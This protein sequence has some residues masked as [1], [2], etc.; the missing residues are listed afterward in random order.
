MSVTKEDVVWCYQNLL[1]REPESAEVVAAHL[2]KRD[3]KQLIMGFLDSKEFLSHKLGVNLAGVSANIGLPPVLDKLDID[4][5]ATGEELGKCAAKIKAAWEHLGNEKPHWS[6]LAAAAYLPDN[7]KVSIDRFWTTGAM[8]AAQAIRALSQFGSSKL[9]EKVCVEYGCG[10]GRVTV[11]LAKSFK[12]VH[13]YDISH[14]HLAHAR[15]RASELGAV[16]IE[17]HE[18]SQDF[19]VAI[20]PCDFFYSIIVL[21]HNPPPVIL[22]LIRIAL[23]ALKPGGIAMFQVPTYIV[24]Y[25]F[26]LSEWLAADHILDMQMHCVPQDRVLQIISASGCQLLGVR[27]DA[28][29]GARDGIISNTFF[30]AK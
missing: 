19:R 11:N 10:V 17:F 24:G 3:F 16:N 12:F 2:E 20:E 21:Q 1:E 22:A 4:V 26:R 5:A 9:D 27:E 18:C 29:A 25:R 28:W 30:C 15:E 7:L 8:D 23:N 6:V 13:A 14:N